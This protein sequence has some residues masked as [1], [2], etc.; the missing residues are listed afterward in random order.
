MGNKIRDIPHMLKK[1]FIWAWINDADWSL[2]YF[3]K[4]KAIQ[5]GKLVI[6]CL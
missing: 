2:A 6:K 1:H 4:D 5:I 3:R